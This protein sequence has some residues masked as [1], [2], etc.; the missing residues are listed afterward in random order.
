[1]SVDSLEILG[2]ARWVTLIGCFAYAAWLDHVERRVPNEHWIAWS[3][4]VIFIWA[5]E[6]ILREAD[7]TI[8]ASAAGVLAYASMSVIGRPTLADIIKGNPLDLLVSAWYLVAV[9]G[10]VAGAM[11]HA[12]GGLTPL[13]DGS[14]SDDTRLWFETMV[15]LT[16]VLLFEFA[17]RLRLLHGGADAKAMMWLAM[18]MPSWATLTPLWELAV[19]EVRSPPAI[20]LFIWGGMVFLLLPFILLLVNLKR[21]HLKGMKDLR[22]AWHSVRL[23]LNE[24]ADKHVWLLDRVIEMP[25]GSSRIHS[26]TRPPRKTPSAEQLASQIDALEELGAKQAWVSLKFPLITMLFPAILPLILFGDPLA[27]LFSRFE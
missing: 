17:W 2:Y 20:S 7:W 13:F 3:K 18:L 25:D 19:V 8:W 11:K 12:T 26:R 23:P 24:I 14:A 15:A 27:L 22:M 6:F 1:M 16:L 21:G 10:I 9:V 5:L 4:P